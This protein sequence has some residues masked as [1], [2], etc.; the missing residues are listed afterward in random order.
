MPTV[1]MENTKERLSPWRFPSA[2]EPPYAKKVYL[3]NAFLAGIKFRENERDKKDNQYPAP[4]LTFKSRSSGVFS[5]MGITSS[6]SYL[7]KNS[8][9]L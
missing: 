6:S 7:A 9:L 2:A 4:Y 8:N 3:I 5:M 1:L